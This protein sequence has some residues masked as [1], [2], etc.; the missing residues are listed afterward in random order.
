MNAK[1]SNV[2]YYEARCFV[3]WHGTLWTR[4]RK[5][6]ARLR[7]C[8]QVKSIAAMMNQLSTQAIMI[9][10][11]HRSSLVLLVVLLVPRR[12]VVDKAKRV[13]MV[14]KPVLRAA[15]RERN[16]TRPKS[17]LAVHHKLC[18]RMKLRSRG[19][20]PWR[21]EARSAFRFPRHSL[22]RNL[23]T[24]LAYCDRSWKVRF[25]TQ[26]TTFSRPRNGILTPIPKSD[27]AS[28]L[29]VNPTIRVSGR[30]PVRSQC[31]PP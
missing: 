26:T 17:Q 24:S 13:S 10:W 12:V 14:R 2:P 9:A 11:A 31:P 15:L 18:L 6:R 3:D 5:G 28:A 25:H 1:E 21:L 20:K 16:G 22:L 23:T 27:S 4:L 29:V 7:G 30:T 19:G 8:L